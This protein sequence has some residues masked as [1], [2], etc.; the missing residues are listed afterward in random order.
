VIALG[1]PFGLGQT[2]TMGIV[3]AKGRMIGVGPYDDF[4]QT[5]ASINPGNSGGPLFDMQGRVVGVNTAI[6]LEGEGIGF[7]IPVDAVREVIDQLVSTGHV[8][9]GRIGIASQR[10]SWPLARLLG[11]DSPRGALVADVDKDGPAER[12][13]I[14]PGDLIVALDG[15]QI[16]TSPELPR[17]VARHLPGATVK[18]T[19]LRDKRE[20]EMDVELLEVDTGEEGVREPTQEE[21]PV[22]HHGVG[23]IDARGGGALVR[24]VV[25]GS[26]ADGELERGDVIVEVNETTITSARDFERL[27]VDAGPLLLKVLRH[28]SAHF[29]ALGPP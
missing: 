16:R 2:V 29:V 21:E 27:S 24:N 13:G 10:V 23:S 14:R 22:E 3:S 19:L 25:P 8:R 15:R 1:N 12:A 4:I 9:R 11:L 5:D 26:A 18:V 28:G 20:R 7:A 6:T 17:V